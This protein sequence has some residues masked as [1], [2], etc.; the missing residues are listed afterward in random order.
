M[1]DHRLCYSITS[2]TSLVIR[3]TFRDFATLDENCRSFLMQHF[4]VLHSGR[5]I[6][7]LH[8]SGF[9]YYKQIITDIRIV[10]RSEE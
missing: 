7:E 2:Q 4:P 6:I 8:S 3:L 5:I 9:V 1:S 10:D